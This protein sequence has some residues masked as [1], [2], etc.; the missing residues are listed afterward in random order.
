MTVVPAAEP[1]D[2]ISRNA[3]R[4][5]FSVAFAK[6]LLQHRVT[7]NQIIII[8]CGSGG[9]GFVSNDWNP[10]DQLYEDVLT[11]TEFVLN[12]FPNSHLKGILWQQGEKEVNRNSPHF[13]EDLDRFI[14]QLRRDLGDTTVPFILGGMV[15]Y[16]IN[17]DSSRIPYQEVI[18]T[19]KDVH[20]YVEYADPE[21]PFV[22]EKTKP[23]KDPIHYDALGQ[24][25]LAE[26]YFQAYLR[27][28]E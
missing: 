18:K 11:R 27:L 21:L 13:E 10:G 5:G 9:T 3:E 8:P 17:L 22:I 15:P 6:K 14:D 16:W 20:D 28:V 7:D 1:L 12:V 25:W 4:I 26:R 19:R 23:D 2:F 24:R